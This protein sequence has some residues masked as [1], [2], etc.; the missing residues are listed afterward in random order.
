MAQVDEIYNAAHGLKESGD[1]EG[2]I[3]K[4]QEGLALEPDHVDTHAA[5]A[6]YYQ[7]L[8]KADEAITHAKKVAELKPDDHFSWMQLSIILQ[9][10]NRIEEAELALAKA[11]EIPPH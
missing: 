3:A 10:C 2:A 1:V 4:L 8:H 6:V 7:K 11:K 9:R 5:L